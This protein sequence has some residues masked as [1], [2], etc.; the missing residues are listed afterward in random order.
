MGPGPGR[1]AGLERSGQGAGE[2]DGAIRA[3]RPLPGDS[4]CPPRA[5]GYQPVMDYRDD[6]IGIRANSLGAL[7]VWRLVLPRPAP[8]R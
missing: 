7:L 2:P 8:G 6:Q 5:L 1:L 3:H 4:T